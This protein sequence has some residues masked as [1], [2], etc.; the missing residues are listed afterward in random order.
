MAASDSASV[1]KLATLERQLDPNYVSDTDSEVAKVKYAGKSD[2][3]LTGTFERLQGMLRGSRLKD[4]GDNARKECQLLQ[5]EIKRRQQAVSKSWLHQ[6]SLGC[7]TCACSSGQLD[8]LLVCRL[9]KIVLKA[10]LQSA[11]HTDKHQ[12]AFVKR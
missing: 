6:V 7:R 5:A 4:G 2:S 9:N 10:S 12:A 3:E 11:A 8:C 1:S